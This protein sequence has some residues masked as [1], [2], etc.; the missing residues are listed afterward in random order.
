MK[1][2][3][4]APQR[5]ALIVGLLVGGG[6]VTA[7]VMAATI[8]YNFQGTVNHV[9]NQLSPPPPPFSTS[10]PS[11]AM[12]GSITVNTADSNVNGNNGT[13]AIQSLQVTIGG[14]TATMSSSGQVSIRDGSGGGSS[15]D[16]FL[17]SVTPLTGNN[18]NFLAPRLFD[19]N[20]R[21]PSGIFSNDGLPNSV[22]SV[23]SF[24]GANEFRLQF[25]PNNGRPSA[26][27]GSLTSLTAVPLP[28]AVVLFGVGLVALIG[29]GAGG[30]RNIRLPQA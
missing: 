30:L 16:R 25:G 1:K 12:S 19:M 2:F 26:V 28:A 20:L 21:G 17:V 23:A 24:T 6:F 11:S 14:Y 29:L 27:I 4:H 15:A 5:L 9:G 18:V 13:Y 7:P 3:I 10:G 8:T 22:P